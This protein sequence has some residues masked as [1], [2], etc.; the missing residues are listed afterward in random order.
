VVVVIHGHQRSTGLACQPG[1]SA[2]RL[3]LRA[4]FWPY[5]RDRPAVVLARRP[6]PHR[7]D[8]CRSIRWRCQGRLRV[9]VNPAVSP[10]RVVL[11]SQ[12]L[13]IP[14]RRRVT[15]RWQSGGESLH[16]PGHVAV[17]QA[18][19]VR[20]GR[21]AFPSTAAVAITSLEGRWC[22]NRPARSDIRLAWDAP[23]VHP[24]M[25]MSKLVGVGGGCHASDGAILEAQAS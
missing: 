19:T 6:L 24:S 12:P 25:A 22:R 15:T 8:C 17:D 21:R 9:Y 14:Y 4:A 20:P 3:A 1:T 11:R 10:V 5:G 7:T 18:V 16:L 23:S 13:L 2:T